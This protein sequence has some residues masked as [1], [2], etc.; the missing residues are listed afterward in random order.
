MNN[1]LIVQMLKAVSK[2]DI[3]GVKSSLAAGAVPDKILINIGEMQNA[4]LLHLAVAG[5][6]AAIIEMLL[7]AGANINQPDSNGMT[8]LHVAANFGHNN[9]LKS[10]AKA[11]ANLEASE[12]QEGLK[13]LHFAA[14]MGHELIVASL[15]EANAEKNSLSSAGMTP[16]H[17]AA[18]GG[19]SHVVKRLLESKADANL[20]FNG[21]TAL[22]I[23]V[24]MGH[25]STA[26][27]LR[28]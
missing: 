2:G 28:A 5:D 3:E 15:L 8:P 14:M 27:V 26:D 1:E 18:A 4:T 20:R 7:A 23:A 12:K 22:E 24:E 9:I 17:Y 11:G 10:L 16:L 6:H 19:Y 25:Q 13:P 21:Q